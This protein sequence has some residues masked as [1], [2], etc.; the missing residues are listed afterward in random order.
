MAWG[1]LPGAHRPQNSSSVRPVNS[2]A[3]RHAAKTAWR[4]A[5]GSAVPEARRA[6]M[7]R[8]VPG[9]CAAMGRAAV[10]QARRAS[11]ESAVPQPGPAVGSWGS[12]GPSAVPQARRA[13]IGRAVPQASAVIMG[14]AAARRTKRAAVTGASGEPRP[15]AILVL[16]NPRR[17]ARLVLVAESRTRVGRGVT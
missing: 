15:E 17:M 9:A 7:G 13:A 2:A 16:L 8:A 3:A 6:A 10:P 12:L 11:L 1:C 5:M 14:S 4:A